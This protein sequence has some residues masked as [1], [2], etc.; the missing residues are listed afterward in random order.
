MQKVVFE[1]ARKN[2]LATIIENAGQYTIQKGSKIAPAGASLRNLADTRNNNT[3]ADN[4][5]TADITLKSLSAVATVISGAQANGKV[6]FKNT[7]LV[8]GATTTASTAP[9]TVSVPKVIGVQTEEKAEEAEAGRKHK[10]RRKRR[11]ERRI[12]RRARAR[13]L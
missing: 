9:V 2:I 7:A 5:T 12:Q 4:V 3:G 6:Y 8:T 10:H 13:K 1:N 11:T